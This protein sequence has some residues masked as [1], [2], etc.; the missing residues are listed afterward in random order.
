MTDPFIQAQRRVA[1]QGGLPWGGTGLGY[2]HDVQHVRARRL[3]PR[4]GEKER[5]Q[6]NSAEARVRT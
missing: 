6:G 2:V 3:A 5:A 4:V 1:M